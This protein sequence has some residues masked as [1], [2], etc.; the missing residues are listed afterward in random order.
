MHEESSVLG[1]GALATGTVLGPL[2]FALSA[3][4]NER[5]WSAAGVD[6]PQ[7]RAGTLYPP[8]AA[9]L[10]ILAFQA[11]C[12]DPVIQTRQR[13]RCHR[14]EAADAEL[15]VTGEVVARYVKR[16][17]AY[18]DVRVLVTNAAGEAVWTSEVSF[19]PVVT[20]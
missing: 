18:V 2:R 13:L 19:T 8:I 3:A 6:H 4:A 16:D 5:Y 9:N 14:A 17:R 15:T 7:L 20:T 10:T 12:G 11:R 1:F